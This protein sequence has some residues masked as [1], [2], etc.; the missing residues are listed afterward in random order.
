MTLL[1]RVRQ[2]VAASQ[3]LEHVR[4]KDRHEPVAGAMD[5]VVVRIGT[6]LAFPLFGAHRLR[7]L[8]D[9]LAAD[10]GHHRLGDAVVVAGRTD[11]RP[12]SERGLPVQFA[13]GASDHMRQLMTG[14][15]QVRV[16]LSPFGQVGQRDLDTG[17]PS[18]RL[19]ARCKALSVDRQAAGAVWSR[20]AAAHDCD[21]G[22]GRGCRGRYQ[23]RNQGHPAHVWSS[24]S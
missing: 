11:I 2:P 24:W 9:V 19:I 22:H 14:C 15:D 7:T 20:R 8:E 21:D 18:E 17:A 13:G 5:A 3:R 12:L 4:A 1:P 10:A 6:R 16:R 23:E